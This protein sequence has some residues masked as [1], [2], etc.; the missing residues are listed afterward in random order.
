MARNEAE[1]NNECGAGNNLLFWALAALLALF[2]YLYFFTGIIIQREV[3]PGKAPLAARQLKQ[4]IPQRPDLQVNKTPVNPLPTQSLPVTAKSVEPSKPPVKSVQTTQ[5]S[6]VIPSQVQG[7]AKTASP[8]PKPTSAPVKQAKALP[9]K[10]KS[11]KQAGS[12]YRLETADIVSATKAEKLI[13]RMKSS[14]I[15]VVGI[16][17]L[18][19]DRTMKRLFVAEFSD[20]T[21][22]T[23]EL[24]KLK[25]ITDGAFII[26][27]GGKYELYAGSYDQPKRAE[28][29]KIRLVG[30]NVNVSLRD[31]SV[32]L[33]AYRVTAQIEGKSAAE[34]WANLLRKQAV[35]SHVYPAAK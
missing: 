14:G 12:L 7:V 23:A 31:A 22:A 35:D 2:G 33:P 11:A 18:Q 32:K 21:T 15:T 8:L 27:T 24:A 4:P 26:R 25:K 34:E 1:Y 20:Q 6:P 30:R 17:K 3:E 9:E 16:N 28:L 13:V 29:E 19:R 5:P 10:V